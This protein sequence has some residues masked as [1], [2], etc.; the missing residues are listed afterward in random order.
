MD[1]VFLGVIGPF[2]LNFIL[3]F[4]R[5]KRWATS[6][7]R[8]IVVYGMLLIALS[9]VIF[10]DIDALYKEKIYAIWGLMTPSI[11]SFLDYLL[12]SLSEQIHDRDLY[13]WLKGSSEIDESKFSGGSHVKAS[14]RLFS[15]ILLFSVTF[16][17]VF[18]VLIL[19]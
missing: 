4:N 10:S 2:V 14:D 12:K 13:L 5:K 17:P 15:M 19:E 11:F 3:L 6:V 8:W 7:Y 16:L 9:I 1:I 18:I